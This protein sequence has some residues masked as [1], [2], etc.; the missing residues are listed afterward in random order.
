MDYKFSEDEIN[1]LVQVVITELNDVEVALAHLRAL[2]AAN[3][4]TFKMFSRKE[5]A[6]I[7]IKNKLKGENLC[8]SN[9]QNN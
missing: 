7:S 9:L 3:T 8:I 1:T 6:L 2:R 4:D 5:E